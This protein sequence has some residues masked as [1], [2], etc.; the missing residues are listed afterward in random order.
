MRKEH[1]A[2]RKAL[3]DDSE[4]AAQLLLELSTERDTLKEETA[5]HEKLAAH[6]EQIRDQELSL[7]HRISSVICLQQSARA[8][9]GIQPSL[10][11]STTPAVPGSPL[12]E[13]AS[14]EDLRSEYLRLRSQANGYHTNS[15][16]LA[17]EY[18]ELASVVKPWPR[19]PALS[20]VGMFD[21]DNDSTLSNNDSLWTQKRATNG[22]LRKHREVVGISSES[23]DVQAIN[24]ALEVDEQRLMKFERVVAAACGDMTLDRVRDVVGPVLSVL[25]NGNTL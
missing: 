8:S 24:A 21:D 16:K 7:K 23:A 2:Q 19:P 5:V 1:E 25:N 18:A 13:K 22:S 20:L 15:L 14:D 9:L 6:C 3:D 17:D 10:T 11:A 12:T 4:Y